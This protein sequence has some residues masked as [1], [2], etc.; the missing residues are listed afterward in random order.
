MKILRDVLIKPAGPDCNL[1]C[2][3]CFYLKKEAMFRNKTVHRMSD[4]VL[5]ALIRQ[6]MGSSGVRKTGFATVGMRG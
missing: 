3:Y 2:A 5:E 6:V 4:N 1:A